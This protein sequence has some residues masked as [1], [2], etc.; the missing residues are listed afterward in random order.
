M[1]KQDRGRHRDVEQS[2]TT[3]ATQSKATYTGEARLS[4]GDTSIK[5]A[6]SSIDDKTGDLAARG[7]RRRVA[8]TIVREETGQGQEES[9]ARSI[10]TRRRRTSSTKTRRGA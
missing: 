6:R 5:A 8:T 9:R 2:S 1:L 4:Q 3:T 7:D 10:A